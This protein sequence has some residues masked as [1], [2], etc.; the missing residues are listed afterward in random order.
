MQHS[1]KLIQYNTWANRL[2]SAPILKLPQIEFEKDLG[3]SF[4][5]LKATMNHLLESDYIWAQRLKGI[6]IAPVPDWKVDSA[7]D[8]CLLW[9]AIQDEVL[10]SV[11]TLTEKPDQSIH[12]ITR[13]GVPYTLPFIEIVFHLSH[14]GSYHRGQLS[15][16]LRM[17]GHQPPSTD[18]F[19]FCTADNQK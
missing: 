17:L 15:N 14:H 3:G 6:P 18:Y 1:I 11:R 7:E 9:T 2:L 16:M 5:S 19:I 8:I 12:F 10:A 13:K 4:G